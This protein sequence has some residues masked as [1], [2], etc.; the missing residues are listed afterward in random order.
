MKPFASIHGLEV[1]SSAEKCLVCDWCPQKNVGMYDSGKDREVS[2]AGH[3]W[4]LK[5]GEAP[6]QTLESADSGLTGVCVM[7]PS[8][9][10][11]GNDSNL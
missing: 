6:L 5:T 8:C 1:E 7:S 4:G 3:R 10:T 2:S 9:S 11:A